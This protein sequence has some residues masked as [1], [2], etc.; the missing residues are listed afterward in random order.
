MQKEKTNK[1]FLVIALIVII[2]IVAIIVGVLLYKKFNNPTNTANNS[3]WTDLYYNYV[4][5]ISNNMEKISEKEES[6]DTVS[7]QLGLPFGVDK[8]S[9]SAEFIDIFEDNTPELILYYNK[10]GKQNDKRISIIKKVDNRVNFDDSNT[11]EE[12]KLLYNIESKTYNYYAHYL[13]NEYSLEHYNALS[14][15]ENDPNY[16]SFQ[17]VLDNKEKEFEEKYIEI[18]TPENKFSI[19]PNMSDEEIKTELK[20]AKENYKDKENIITEEVKATTE[21]KA[22]EMQQEKMVAEEQTKKETETQTKAEEETKKKAKEEANKG[23]KV[24]NYTL[25]Y[26]TYVGYETLYD[27][28]GNETVKHTVVINQDGTLTYNGNTSK[29][30]ISGNYIKGN[31]GM[32][33]QVTGDSQ[34]TLEAGGGVKFT[35]QG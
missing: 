29:Y 27:P 18:E 1:K 35:Y 12:I 13:E 8:E 16:K 33:F 34:F 22:E 5:E 6:K 9:V 32:P 2:L 11:A 15:S 21:Q 14:E 23:L 26:G 3:D 17:F 25:K 31:S 30:T 19:K 10:K 24:G 7:Y 28:S 4:K 20:N